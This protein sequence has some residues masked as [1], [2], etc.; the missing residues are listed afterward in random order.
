MC[1]VAFAGKEREE[2]VDVGVERCLP[3]WTRRREVGGR[4][5]RRARMEAKVDIVVDE[6]MVRGMAVVVVSLAAAFA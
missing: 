6:G 2:S 5:V 3:A 4:F 1:R